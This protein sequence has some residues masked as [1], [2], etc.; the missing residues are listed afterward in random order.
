MEECRQPG[1]CMLLVQAA[2]MMRE[3]EIRSAL[4]STNSVSQGETVANLWRP[5]FEMGIH[6]DFAYRTFIWDSEASMKAHV[7]C[8]IIGFSTAINRKPKFIFENDK[9]QEVKH[10]NGYLIEADDVF[11]DSRNKPISNVPSICIGSQ[12]IDDGNFL[13]SK[14]EMDE[15]IIKEPASKEYFHLWYGSQEFINRNPRYC[16]YLGDCSPSKLRTM[17]ECMKRVEAVREFRLKSNR[18]V[19]KKAAD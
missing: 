11:V 16:L 7:H 4:V 10:I 13:F 17:S 3:T 1:L 9:P 19:T 14:D 2:E 18:A 8:V 5:L 12:P 6:L 15:F